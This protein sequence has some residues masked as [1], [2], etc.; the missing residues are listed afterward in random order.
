MRGGHLQGV[1]AGG[2]GNIQVRSEVQTGSRHQVECGSARGGEELLLR[3]QKA[4]HPEA[5]E[6]VEQM[7]REQSA[8]EEGE[9]RGE[10]H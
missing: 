9:R 2:A 7:L 10:R 5:G 1:S 3:F 4:G 8:N 6:A